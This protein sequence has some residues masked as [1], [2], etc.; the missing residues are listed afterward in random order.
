[1]PKKAK[2]LAVQPMPLNNSHWEARRG[3]IFLFFSGLDVAI[4]HVFFFL[5]AMTFEININIHE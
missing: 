3:S 1:M 5:N 2:T 4:S